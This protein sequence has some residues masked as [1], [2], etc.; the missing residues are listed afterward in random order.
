MSRDAATLI[1]PAAYLAAGIVAGTCYFFCL[2]WNARRL[3]ERRR[4]WLTILLLPGR[5]V[6][7]GFVL[8]LAARQGAMPLL[9]MALGVLTARFAVMRGLRA[10]AS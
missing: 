8:T 9:L 6:L 3:A 10:A 2:W 7:L 5:L 4:G 1:I